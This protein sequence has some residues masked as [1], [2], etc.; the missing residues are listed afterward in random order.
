MQA[1]DWDDIELLLI[2]LLARKEKLDVRRNLLHTLKKRLSNTTLD[3]LVSGDTG[4]DLDPGPYVRRQLPD[5]KRLLA[6]SE[7]SSSPGPSAGYRMIDQIR[8]GNYPAVLIGTGRGVS[9]WLAG[10]VCYMAEIP[11]RIG[12]SCEF[13][14]GVLSHCIDPPG[15]AVSGSERYDYLLEEAGIRD[16]RGQAPENRDGDPNDR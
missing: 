4:P 15:D 3:L 5:R 13:G 7:Q 1:T 16:T 12:M 11:V 10:Y 9:P 6:R 8:E 14:G 2:L